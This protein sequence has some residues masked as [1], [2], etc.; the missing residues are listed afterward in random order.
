VESTE[1]ASAGPG[2]VIRGPRVPKQT[3]DGP[4]Y[5][6][7]LVDLWIPREAPAPESEGPPAERTD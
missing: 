4:A 2:R 1:K 3:P 6:R 7:M 5:N